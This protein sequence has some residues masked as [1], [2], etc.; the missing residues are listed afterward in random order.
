[1]LV[2]ERLGTMIAE[3]VDVEPQDFFRRDADHRI[4]ATRDAVRSLRNG[5][6]VTEVRAAM[7]RLHQVDQVHLRTVRR[8]LWLLYRLGTVTY[9][10]T[11]DGVKIWRAMRWILIT[12][13][14][15]L[16]LT[17]RA[18][19]MTCRLGLSS[20]AA[21]QPIAGGYRRADYSRR[22]RFNERDFASVAAT[23]AA[24]QPFILGI[25]A[26]ANAIMP[27]LYGSAA[28]FGSAAFVG[29]WL[30]QTVAVAALKAFGCFLRNYGDSLLRDLAVWLWINAIRASWYTFGDYFLGWLPWWRRDTRP[31]RP[32]PTPAPPRVPWW[33]RWRK[34]TEE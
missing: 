33:R 2:G 30:T 21:G 17:K 24:M 5:G 16:T 1:M 9:Q 11:S 26:Y 34:S 6:T 28:G 12:D 18:M 20:P 27:D 22:G 7:M 32:I 4:V 14:T 19:S 3:P 25:E 13:D 8:D 23:T 29:R 15:N 10:Q 31:W